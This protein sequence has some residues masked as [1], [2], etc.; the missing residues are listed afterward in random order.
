[1]TYCP[2]KLAT[3]RFLSKDKTTF[4]VP[5]SYDPATDGCDKELCGFWS[6]AASACGIACI[7]SMMS[8][9]VKESGN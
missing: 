5:G 8:P 6:K 1:M 2:I 7:A 4:N 3:S 9:G